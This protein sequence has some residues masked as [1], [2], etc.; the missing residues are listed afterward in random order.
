[1]FPR[2][3]FTIFKIWDQSKYPQTEQARKL[4]YI[5]MTEYYSDLKKGNCLKAL[6]SVFQH[7][8]E[9]QKRILSFLTWMNMEDIVFHEISQAQKDKDLMISLIS[10]IQKQENYRSRVEQWLLRAGSKRGREYGEMLFRVQCREHSL[11][12]I[13]CKVKNNACKVKNNAISGLKTAEITSPLYPSL[14]FACV[15]LYALLYCFLTV[16]PPYLQGYT[17]APSVCL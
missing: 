8:K 10:E 16:V 5:Y 13:Q 6:G 15:V 11:F 17:Q 7:C 3:L 4:W 14:P 1:M 12:Q 9:N 2:E